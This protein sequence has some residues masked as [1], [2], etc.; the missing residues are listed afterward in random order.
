[1]P[2]ADA[3]LRGKASRQPARDRQGGKALPRFFFIN[4]VWGPDYVDLL[5]EFSIPTLLAPGNIPGLPNRE[6]CEFIIVAPERDGERIRASAIYAKLAETIKVVFVPLELSTEHKYDQMSRGHGLAVDY[7][8]R[9]G[10]CIFLAPDA[11]VSDGMMKRLFDLALQG[12]RV[13]AG[14][15]PRVDQDA[16][17]CILRNLAQYR[18]GE[19]LPLDPRR[20]VELT[21]DNLHRDLRHHFVDSPCFPEQPYACVWPGPQGDGMLV[22]SLNLHPYLFDAQ[23]IPEGVGFDPHT[24]T[25]D[26]SV[27]PRFLADWNDLYVEKDS[28]NF[29]VVGMTPAGI[30]AKPQKDNR[31]DAEKLSFWLLRLRYEVINRNSFLY[32]IVF[33]GRPMNDEW[34]ELIQRTGEFALQVVDPARTLRDF[35]LLG[36]AYCQ[37]S[38]N[39]IAAATRGPQPDVTAMNLEAKP[40][41]RMSAANVGPSAQP[42]PFFY[43]F[44]VWGERYIDYLCRFG[45]PS[46]LSPRNLPALSNNDVSTFIIVTTA[47]DEV[48]I[49]ARDAYRLLTRF[50]NVEFHHLP[51]DSDQLPTMSDTHEK[52]NL[53]TLGHSIAADRATGQGCAIFL[54]PDAVYSDGMLSRLLQLAQAGKKVVV[55]MGPRVNEETIVPELTDR[56]LLREGEPLVVPPRQAVGLLLR[57]LHEDARLLRWSSPLFPRTP[58]MC[59]WDVSGG[60]GIVIR[61][62][63]LHPYL[64]DYRNISGWRPRPKDTSAVDASFIVNCVV[65]WEKIYQVTDTDDFLVLSL[66]SMHKRDYPREV[67]SDPFGTLVASSQRH[68]ITMLHRAYFMHAIKMHAG[69]LDDRWTQLEQETLK[70]AYDV[71]GGPA[72]TAGLRDLSEAYALVRQAQASAEQ[73]ARELAAGKINEVLAG[74]LEGVSGRLAAKVVLRKVLKRVWR[75]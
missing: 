27:L 53:L 58:Y 29:C 18:P 25:V 57:H 24:M 66:T 41:N 20:L 39:G 19:P 48:R 50:I 54:G 8:A 28:D 31:L 62:F 26:W 30:L 70:I 34:T 37:V 23:L 42:I 44:S 68:D 38:E 55:G 16:T 61:S 35:T 32:P 14:F 22:R 59:V 43:A 3:R 7:V 65:P 60:D 49:R 13:V 52:Y 64:V 10:F 40:S 2:V 46:L 71:L 45:I 6:Q 75:R 1:M 5:T 21:M 72:G 17:I 74:D 51:V 56:G 9:R 11:V 15:G 4:V 12:R 33:H 63:S 36:R 69:D 67:N 73:K 47:E